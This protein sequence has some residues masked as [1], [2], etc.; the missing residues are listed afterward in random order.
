MYKVKNIS[1]SILVVYDKGGKQTHIKPGESVEM[2][3]PPKESYQFD[4]EKLEELKKKEKI[5]K[6]DK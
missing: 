2:L 5:I 4:V 6:E 3:V 1:K